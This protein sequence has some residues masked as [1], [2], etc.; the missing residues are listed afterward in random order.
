[1]NTRPATNEEYTKLNQGSD[2]EPLSHEYLAFYKRVGVLWFDG[3][4][5]TGRICIVPEKP[6]PAVLPHLSLEFLWISG[7]TRIRCECREMTPTAAEGHARLFL[8]LY[9]KSGAGT[10]DDQT[11]MWK[12]MKWNVPAAPLEFPDASSPALVREPITA[13]RP[14]GKARRKPKKSDPFDPFDGILYGRA[15][16]IA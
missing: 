2:A 3:K 7:G 10:G 6:F 15:L 8:S 12:E 14:A 5:K 13:A 4:N 1:M 16:S 9:G 11:G